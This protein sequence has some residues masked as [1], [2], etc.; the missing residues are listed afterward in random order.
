MR[1]ASQFSLLNDK[2]E[3]GPEHKH[4]LAAAK[5]HP[6]NKLLTEDLVLCIQEDI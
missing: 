5:R 1:Y 6:I 4:K 2:K 3:C